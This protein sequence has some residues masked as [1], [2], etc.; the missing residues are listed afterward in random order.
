LV[1]IN[2]YIFRPLIYG[3]GESVKRHQ[4]R[5]KK[6]KTKLNFASIQ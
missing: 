4:S 3:G 6:E 5:K 2:I 1:G